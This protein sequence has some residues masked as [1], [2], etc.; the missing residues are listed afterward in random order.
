MKWG[1]IAFL[2]LEL[3]ES[4]VKKRV[5]DE[6]G[7]DESGHTLVVIGCNNLE[8][9]VNLQN[10]RQSLLHNILDSGIISF[11]ATYSVWTK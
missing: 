4:K 7:N 2:L 10:S 1:A 6:R 11:V 5:V 9:L 3:E 8:A